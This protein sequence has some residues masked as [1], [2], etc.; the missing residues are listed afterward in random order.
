MS[1]FIP[2]SVTWIGRRAFHSSGLTSLTF[3]GGSVLK[4]MDH[5]SF[6]ETSLT[7][8]VVPSTIEN[9]NEAFTKSGIS[10][11]FLPTL[12]NVTFM[13]VPTALNEDSTKYL[14]GSN[15]DLYLP[16]AAIY[17]ESCCGKFLATD[18]MSASSNQTILH[19]GNHEVPVT[20]STIS[21][22]S[23]DDDSVV[24]PFVIHMWGAGGTVHV[25]FVV[26]A[27]APLFLLVPSPHY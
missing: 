5:Y 12:A 16:F 4:M 27:V 25:S 3:E 21:G 26:R 7:S 10:A 22:P 11:E 19:S 24:L 17:S 8:V 15:I 14:V 20:I 23:S 6:G 18:F 1:V 2:A 13:D 9:M